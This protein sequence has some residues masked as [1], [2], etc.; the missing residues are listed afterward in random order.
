VIPTMMANGGFL[1]LSPRE[2]L[3]ALLDEGC[4]AELAGPFDRLYSP[5]LL[6]QGATPQSDDGVVVV[7]GQ[8]GGKD[9]VGIAIEGAFEGGS[10]GEVGGAKIA[11]ALELAAESC[12]HGA[13]VAALLLLETGGVRL[14]EATLGLAAIAAI[15]TAILALR[16]YA[17]VV[18]LIAGP[19]GCFGGMSLAAELCS[20]ILGT[21]HGRLGMNGPEVIEQEAG[22]DEI[23]A[24]D[25]KAIWQ[26]TGCEARRRDGWIDEVVQDDAKALRTAVCRAILAGPHR[27]ERLTEPESKLE[28]L[29]RGF[30]AASKELQVRANVLG[31]GRAWLERLS[32]GKLQEASGARS[33]LAAEIALPGWVTGAVAIGIVPDAGS[34]LPRAAHGELGL[35]QG[36]ALAAYLDHF[37][38]EERL[39]GS[40]RPIIAVVDTPGQ[41]FGRVEEERCISAAAAAAIEA[42]ARARDRFWPMGCSPT[43]SSR[44]PMSP[45]ACM[46]WVRSPWRG[47]RGSLWPRCRRRRPGACRCRSPSSMRI[48]LASSIRS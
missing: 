16:T 42:Y 38:E 30:A 12:R 45:S 29:R 47:S 44:S 3:A 21:P 39:A 26:M 40:R 34:M 36:W 22:A 19:V 14:Q 10:V 2:R 25:R 15:Q 17:P 13:P 4:L 7:R 9:V 28:D 20:Y 37:V 46:R 41:A 6:L 48:V 33:V 31:R 27:P 43:I 18:A 5:W 35:E 1:E 23:D 32:E 11:K 24:G 8:I